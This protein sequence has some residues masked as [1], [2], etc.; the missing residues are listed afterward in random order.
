MNCGDIHWNLGLKQRPEKNGRYLQSIGSWNSH[1]NDDCGNLW[2]IYATL[3]PVRELWKRDTLTLNANL[4]DILWFMVDITIFTMEN[5]HFFYRTS[6]HGL[7]GCFHG[8]KLK[9]CS[10]TSRLGAA[11][12]GMVGWD[13]CSGEW[14]GFS[15]LYG[16]LFGWFFL[17]AEI[18]HN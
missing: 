12:C 5:H 4:L 1:W 18:S 15:G 14:L 3:C 9:Q 7:I 13:I 8:L 2:N 11:S 10:T 6:I 16:W 17:S